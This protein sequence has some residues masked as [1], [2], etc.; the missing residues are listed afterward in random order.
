MICINL[1]IFTNYL[2]ALGNQHAAQQF[3][4]TQFIIIFPHIL[5]ET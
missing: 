3:L 2:D 4:I 5:M 1:S